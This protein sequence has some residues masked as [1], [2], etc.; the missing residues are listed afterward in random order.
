MA[1]WSVHKLWIRAVAR[2]DILGKTLKVELLQTCFVI[3][4][5]V[6]KVRRDFFFFFFCFFISTEGFYFGRTWFKMLLTFKASMPLLANLTFRNGRFLVSV[7]SPWVFN[8][9][10]HL[11]FWLQL[12][13]HF[14]AI[15]FELFRLHCLVKDHWWGFN[16]RNT[17][18]V[19]TV[20]SISIKMMYTS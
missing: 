4:D 19:H 12:F 9:L 5:F 17:H 11:L 2:W 16:T 7:G 18:M 20:Y 3:E 6:L 1:T 13:R 8:G 14:W 10:L 15:T